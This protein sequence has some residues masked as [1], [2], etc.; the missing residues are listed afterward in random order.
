MFENED[1]GINNH[2]NELLIK[3]KLKLEKFTPHASFY[4]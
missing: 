2:D 4:L 1:C 3:F